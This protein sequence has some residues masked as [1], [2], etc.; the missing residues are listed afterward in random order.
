MQTGAQ[1][2][3]NPIKHI[4]LKRPEQAF[5]NQTHIDREWQAYNYTAAPNYQKASEEYEAFEQLIRKHV[6]HVHLLPESEHTGLDSIYTHDSVKFTHLGALLLSPGKTARAKE[7]E[8]IQRFL[9]QKKI[10]I[11]GSLTGSARAEGGDIVWLDEQTVAIGR[12]YRTN[13]EGIAQLQTL[14]QDIVREIIIVD[15]PHADG[16]D[17]C[18]HLMSIISMVDHDLAVV[19]SR[20]MTVTFRKWLVEKGITLIEV[21]DE[22]YETLGSNLLAIAP[23]KCVIL[24][25]NSRTKAKLEAAGA[26]VIEYSG[27]EIS[28]KGTGGP[29][30]LTCPILRV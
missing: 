16:A 25:G 15:L 23:R 6:P 1:S 10:P 26:T 28:Y 5:R 20:Y 19:Y 8:A 2:M 12:G 14:L 18:L 13:Q 4:L 22:E 27:A 11:L 21:D 29:T 9:E 3:V 17:E 24:A 7:P 30:C